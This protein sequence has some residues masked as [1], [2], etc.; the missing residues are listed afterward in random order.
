VF[1]R[2]T[3][4]WLAAAALLA[5]ALIVPAA[6]ADSGP[7][8]PICPPSPVP[9]VPGI[10]TCPSPTT[11]PAPAAAAPGSVS[12]AQRT[13]SAS[14]SKQFALASTPELA[15]A[16]L[17]A[18][19][20]TR[21]AHGLRALRLSAALTEA[22]YAHAQSLAAAGQFTHAWPTTNRVF[23]R[24]IRNFYSARGYRR[25]SAGE[26]LLWASPSFA[27]AG[28]VQQWLASPVHRRVMLTP[29]WRELRVGVVAATAAPGAYGGKDVQIAAAEFGKRS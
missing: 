16:L 11:S 6:G 25:W 1:R 18:V 5:A 17:V 4:T 3:L 24:W 21:R 8:P 7:V 23:G 14:P 22:A 15:R 26:N 10:T 20:A 12:S 27:A 28:A 19:N 2:R 13:E 29:S 9:L